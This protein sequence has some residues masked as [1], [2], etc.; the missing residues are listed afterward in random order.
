M[1]GITED[2][3]GKKVGGKREDVTADPP[4]ITRRDFA[5]G[6]MALLGARP[7]A[8]ANEIQPLSP[9]IKAARLEIADAVKALLEER[10]IL[11]EDLRRV[12][13]HAEQTG[14]KLCQNET[15]RLLSKLWVQYAYFYV[16]YSPMTDGFRIHSAYSH[17]LRLEER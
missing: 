17:R 16:E 3:S 14:D 6:S 10:H 4:R 2:T 11:D 5:I 7:L 9:E 12:I 1:S 8:Q 15:D 13:D